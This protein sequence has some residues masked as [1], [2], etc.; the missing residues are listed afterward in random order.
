MDGVHVDYY[1]PDVSTVCLGSLEVKLTSPNG[2]IVPI[3]IP[4]PKH[5]VR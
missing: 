5:I 2:E 3:M 4:S 1:E